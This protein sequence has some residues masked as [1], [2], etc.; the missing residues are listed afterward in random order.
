MAHILIV[1]DDI[2]IIE[3]SRV[4]LELDGHK[5]EAAH[6]RQSGLK[7]AVESKP[8]LIIL[9]VMMDEP[10]DGFA[11]AQDLRSRGMSMPIIMMTS[12]S[13]VSGYAF[14]VDSDLLPVDDFLPK[15]VDPTLLREKVLALLPA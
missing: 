15:P 8:D 2:D 1:D 12:V 7:S 4:L 5:V 9:D 6:T 14:G 11:L 10:D 3:A 13:H